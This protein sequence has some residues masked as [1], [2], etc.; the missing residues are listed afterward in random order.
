MVKKF[1]I[2]IN[3]YFKPSTPIKSTRAINSGIL[4]YGLINFRLVILEFTD[5]AE[6]IEREQHY[7]GTYSPFYNVLKTANSLLGFKHS[8][9]TRND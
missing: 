5:P 9:L 2:R 1:N 8:A 3:S 4:K 7:I 6:L